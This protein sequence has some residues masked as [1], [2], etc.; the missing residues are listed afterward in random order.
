MSD[1]VEG[2][3]YVASQPVDASEESLCREAMELCPAGAIADDG[4]ELQP[5][6]CAERDLQNAAVQ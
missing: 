5:V 1:D 3:S 2:H 6:I 4:F